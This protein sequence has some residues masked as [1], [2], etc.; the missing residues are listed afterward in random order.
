MK[1]ALAIVLA[2]AAAVGAQIVPMTRVSFEG[3]DY[4]RAADLNVGRASQR[5]LQRRAQARA[6]AAA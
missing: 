4:P 6:R 5:L 3:I 2:S 1:L